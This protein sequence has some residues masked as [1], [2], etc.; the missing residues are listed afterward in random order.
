MCTM[1]IL[2]ITLIFNLYFNPEIKCGLCVIANGVAHRP[3]S[4]FTKA[5]AT[6]NVAKTM[7]LQ[8]NGQSFF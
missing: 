3:R 8:I 6:K 1:Q 2:I 7:K 4:H 5:I